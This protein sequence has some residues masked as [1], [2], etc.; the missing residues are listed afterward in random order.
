MFSPRAGAGL[1]EQ[2]WHTSGP[3]LIHKTQALVPSL[4][5]SSKW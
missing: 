3:K 4:K 5:S 1:R 2:C